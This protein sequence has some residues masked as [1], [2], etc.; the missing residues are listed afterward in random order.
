[1][2][3]KVDK[4]E[5]EQWLYVKL[6]YRCQ[7]FEPSSPIF[8]QSRRST[9]DT[10]N[11]PLYACLLCQQKRYSS[12]ENMTHHC[13][14]DN[15]HINRMATLLARQE[16]SRQALELARAKYTAMAPR[17]ARLGCLKWQRI[18]QHELYPQAMSIIMT[19]ASTNDGVDCKVEFEFQEGRLAFFE[20]MERI[21][22]LELAIWKAACIMEKTEELTYYAMLEWKL[23]GWKESKAK[24]RRSS[25][26]DVI[27]RNTLP[28]LS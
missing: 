25:A 24:M 10:G 3:M 6:P 11:E 15:G 28:F 12:R 13:L 1:M 14:N 19:G 26:I 20:T 8:Q 21:S 5:L 22:L 18:I 27:I 16:S 7:G 9:T 2:T 4:K 23:R 17:I